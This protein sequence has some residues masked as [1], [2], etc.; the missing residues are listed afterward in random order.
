LN[1]LR[2]RDEICPGL[3]RSKI[4][5]SKIGGIHLGQFTPT[6]YSLERERGSF[7]WQIVWNMPKAI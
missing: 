5:H 7:K 3:G 2:C 6:G 1:V 4:A